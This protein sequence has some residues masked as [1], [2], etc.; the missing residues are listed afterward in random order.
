[1][2]A[3]VAVLAAFAFF[4]SLISA[5][6]RSTLLTGPMFFIGF[7]LLVGPWGL[8]I[9]DITVDASGVR[10]L[11][12]WTL[13]LVLFTDAADANRS[14]L[15]RKI[16]ISERMLLL[17]LPLAMLLG[18]LLGWVMFGQLGLYQAAIVAT[19]LAAT[20][21]ALG[22]EC[23]HDESVPTY[24][25]TGLNVE[26]GLNDGMT[27]PVLLVL[28]SLSLAAPG[29]GLAVSDV[30]LIVMREISIGVLVGVATVAIGVLLM[31]QAARFGWID[32]VWNQIPVI[33]L[34]VCSFAIAQELHGSGYIAAFCGGLMFRQLT[35]RLSHK[36]TATATEAGET[37]ALLV[38]VLFGTVMLDTILPVFEWPMLLYGFLSLTVIR[39]AAIILS[40]AGSGETLPAKIYL[41][42][43]GPRGLASIVFVVIVTDAGVSGADYIAGVVFCTILMSVFMH[44][45]STHPFSRVLA[46]A[47]M[48]EKQARNQKASEL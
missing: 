15:V 39:T 20:D 46:K 42:W 27:V 2:I 25:R 45:L 14:A 17:G 34:A 19:C 24:M 41:G 35:K 29:A 9:I 13:A 12:D 32:P 38:W 47:D 1:M 11:A 28:I 10:I 48:L 37:M 33:A 31:Q 43:F 4:F 8:R 36:M 23:L 16:G 22:K 30:I 7:G 6:I 40:L 3:D 26:S 18:T 44:G 21:A 5:R